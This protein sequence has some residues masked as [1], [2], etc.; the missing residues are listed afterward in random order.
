[1]TRPKVSSELAI[2]VV[3]L[4]EELIAM[5]DRDPNPYNEHYRAFLMDDRPRA[6]EI[7][8]R[9][10]EIEGLDLM[11]VA[12]DAVARKAKSPIAR[13]HLERAWDEIGMW[14]S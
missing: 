7:G 10:N 2:E 1:M 4:I 14:R 13:A 3:Q 9:L 5:S 12:C 8:E 6:R 11:L